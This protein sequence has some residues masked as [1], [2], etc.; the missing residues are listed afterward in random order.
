MRATAILGGLAFIAI[1]SWWNRDDHTQ[2]LGCADL[3]PGGICKAG[4]GLVR[5]ISG[6][7]SI[8]SVKDRMPP[9]NVPGAIDPAITQENIDRTICR[10]G[11]A[12]SARPAYSITGPYKHQMMH[13]QHPGG[14]MADYELD[15]LIPISLGGAPFD[16]Q[17]LWLQAE[18]GPANAK[19][20][21]VLEY[22]LWRMVCQH[23]VTLAT[24][25]RAIS[26]NWITAFQ[27]YA[28]PE[29]IAK[30]HFHAEAGRSRMTTKSENFFI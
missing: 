8:L 1:A 23:E 11:Y 27:T 24:A 25:Q 7:Q 28:T 14:R 30:Y 13:Q 2:P 21:D 16:A 6:M 19:D 17:D 29:N 4:A 3:S 26:R 9:E 22:V 5:S 15:H 12:R 20:K 18:A 10:P